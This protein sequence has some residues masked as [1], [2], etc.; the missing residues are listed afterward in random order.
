VDMAVT[1]EENLAQTGSASRVRWI[2]PD[3]VLMKNRRLDWAVLT[4]EA[5]RP[6]GQAGQ[7]GTGILGIELRQD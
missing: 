5:G 1:E 2:Y 6:I 4:F 3:M 7:I